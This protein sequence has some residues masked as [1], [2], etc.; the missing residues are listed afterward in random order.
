[1]VVD[2]NFHADHL[3][4]KYPDDDVALADGLGFMVES[5]PYKEHISVSVESKQVC[6]ILCGDVG[7]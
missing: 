4:M 6:F 2:G 3:K 5:G 1:L 7:H